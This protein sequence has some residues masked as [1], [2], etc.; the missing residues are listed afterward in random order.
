MS[1]LLIG[2]AAAVLVFYGIASLMML[3]FGNRF[4][5][6][7]P[8]WRDDVNGL[9]LLDTGTERFGA[10]YLPP[11]DDRAYVILHSHGNG[12][13]L[14]TVQ[15]W[16]RTLHDHGYGVIGY[17]YPGYGAST[18]TPDEAGVYRCVETAYRYLTETAKIPPER[19]ISMG[20][21]LGTGPATYIAAKERTAGLL[22]EAPYSTVVEAVIPFRSPVNHF[23][24]ID[25]IRKINCPLIV[26]HGGK[27][28]VV[29]CRSGKKLFNHARPPKEMVFIP[30]GT[31]YNLHNHLG[32]RYW[33]LLKSL[34]GMKPDAESSSVVR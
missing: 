6:H 2:I 16:L 20:Y 17:D 33:D 13:N 26:I 4:M 18:G 31:H 5:F 10:L 30:D 28:T 21:S 1:R 19:I 8:R 27:D 7:P 23:C 14:S 24:S 3:L 25:R 29:A 32:D 22:L 9:M 15:S 11:P 12:E 34:P